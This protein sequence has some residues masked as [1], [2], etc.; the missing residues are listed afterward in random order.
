[1]EAYEKAAKNINKENSA[2]RE[3]A[4]TLIKHAWLKKLQ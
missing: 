3:I 4:A 1:M 2:K